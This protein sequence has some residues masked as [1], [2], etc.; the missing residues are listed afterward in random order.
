MK[1]RLLLV[2]I[3][4]L[5]S[6]NVRAE[7]SARAA[8]Q[9][10]GLFVQSCIRFAQNPQGLR[11]WVGEVKLPA[12]PA[13]GQQAFL[14]GRSGIA[15]DATNAEGKYVLVSGDDGSCSTIAQRADPSVLATA[16]ERFL[17]QAGIAL[18]SSDQYDDPEEKSLHWGTWRAS[19]NNRRWSILVGT[20]SGASGGQAMLTA[21]AP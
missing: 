4:L 19:K 10:A 21:T 14:K 9:V 6:P 3:L 16:L 15:Y 7:D 2:C 11:K 20:A 8:E 5:L 12:L 13:P 18:E 17:K 1:N